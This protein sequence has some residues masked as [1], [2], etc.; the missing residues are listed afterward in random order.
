MFQ[1]RIL[2]H[3][4]YDISPIEPL[5]ESGYVILTPNSRLAR[6]IKAE[7][8]KQRVEAGDRVWEPVQVYPLMNWLQ[9]QW[10]DAVALELL[11][12][13][14]P[15]T[16]LQAQELWRH[17]IDA[18]QRQSEDFHLL[19]PSAAAELAGTARDSLQLWQVPM[20][21]GAT[22]QSF[23]LD[24]DCATFLE[25]LDAFERKLGQGNQVTPVDRI[26]Q[27][28][29]LAD[30][31]PLGKIALVESGDIAPLL[32]CVLKLLCE[33]VLWVSPVPGTVQCLSHPF[34]DNRAQLQAVARWAAAAHEQDPAKTLGIVLSDMQ[35]DRVPLEYLLRREF[36]CL[37]SNYTS[38]P[39]NFSTGIALSQAP[40][41]RDGLATLALGLHDI[42]V[43]Q[44][45]S[46]LQSRFVDLP[47]ANTPLAHYFVRRLFDQGMEIVAVAELR[48][49][50]CE[51]KR[52]DQKGLKLG[53]HLLTQS[54]MH[55]LKKKALPSVWAQQF[56][57]VL[58]LWGWPGIA[59]L[60]SLEHQQVGLWHKTLDE[61]KS[62]DAL[63]KSL[64][65]AGALKL[66]R[67]HCSRQMSQ[68]Q[69][70]DSAVQ[71]L[72]PLEAAGLAFDELWV[73]GMQA[74]SWPESPRPNP[75]IPP[76][77]QSRLQMPHATVQRQWQV[78]E[79][80][81]QQYANHAGVLHASYCQQLDGVPDQPS[82]LLRQFT[83][84]D[85]P[86]VMLIPQ[87]WAQQQAKN[88]IEYLLDDRAPPAEQDELEE[89][90]GGSALLEDQSQCPFR[91][92][93]RRRLRIEPLSEFSVAMTAAERG[94][95]LHKALDVLWGDIGS[96]N[97]LL[98]LSGQDEVRLIERA[99]Q[100][101]ID[102][103]SSV[104]KRRLG[105]SYL[106]LEGQ[107]LFGVL[108]EWLAVERQR[109]TFVV[110]QRE[111]E[112]LLQ[113]GQ[114]KLKLRVDRVDELA[115]G[116]RM[117][118]DYKSGTSNVKDWLG[119]RPA[120]PQLLLYGIA[121]PEIPAALAFAQVRTRDCAFVGLG[122]IET[123]PGVSNDM[124]AV[125]KA[126]MKAEDWQTLNDEWK[127]NLE[128]IAQAFVAGDAEVDPLAP[129][130]CQWCG[131]QSLCRIEMPEVTTDGASQ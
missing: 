94:S 117:V 10:A 120:K 71:V 75:F 119:E 13:S 95:L 27:L 30:Q 114:L 123:V 2:P 5:I 101:A 113:L 38:L 116:S 14:V 89:L 103:M 108:S 73:C 129:T 34:N 37:G 106:Q 97:T 1:E 39:V 122:D 83:I 80:L 93:A 68:P 51:V 22:R 87:E 130:S 12:P 21:S 55:A 92:F 112:V 28:S 77:I 60:D 50:A 57:E 81:L 64:D 88:T 79:G 82:P 44:V 96:H 70:G 98:E 19:R 33:E 67:E 3:S 128:R 78:S 59:A 17:T 53:E 99:A 125:V 63:G 6:R 42:A 58:A 62:Y 46:V 48:W 84:V 111:Q 91:A 54:G 121:S 45:I 86:E 110:A 74:G 9:M 72:G 7:W 40:V 69:T 32:R 26:T 4:L 56:S 61:L 31:L 102:D 8:D 90:G 43:T 115:D 24:R 52:G 66:L 100:V 127:A 18:H 29:T 20:G 76:Q 11:P 47:D 49:D 65:Y 41:V 25:W 124:K 126:G 131:L 109:E 15:L 16:T 105:V 35:T 104:R 107:R 36:D 118:I 85:T 23:E